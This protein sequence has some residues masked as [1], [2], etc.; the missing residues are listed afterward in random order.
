M[1]FLESQMKPNR[2]SSRRGKVFGEN[3]GF[4]TEEIAI[5]GFVRE[6]KSEL[7]KGQHFSLKETEY[8]KVADAFERLWSEK[9]VDECAFMS[10]SLFSKLC[11]GKQYPS[12][13]W[14]KNI[15]TLFPGLSEKWFD[16]YVFKNRMQ[17]HLAS[18]DLFHIAS[19]CR[20]FF[21]MRREEVVD[22][23]TICQE[24]LIEA[25]KEAESI[26]KL[27]HED[28]EPRNTG[29]GNNY[30]VRISGPHERSGLN[31]VDNLT[32][33]KYP[34]FIDKS[35]FIDY[36]LSL[37]EASFIGLSL[38]GEIVNTYQ[39][40]NPF[41]VVLFLFLLVGLDQNTKSEYR[42][43][44]ILDFMTSLNC[45]GLILK[46]RYEGLATAQNDMAVK[47]ILSLLQNVSEYFHDKPFDISEQLEACEQSLKHAQKTRDATSLYFYPTPETQFSGYP[48][49]ILTEIFLETL[50]FHAD[51]QN[52]ENL[53]EKLQKFSH[54][55]TYKEAKSDDY[56]RSPFAGIFKSFEAS[57]ERYLEQ[58]SI[59]GYSRD[60]LIA[61]LNEIITN[62]IVI[63]WGAAE[64]TPQ[65]PSPYLRRK[66]PTKLC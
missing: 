35:E 2:Y 61:E 28:W 7:L 16:R 20:C 25:V 19:D 43:D 34:D 52:I 57:R 33:Y 41:S 31:V 4:R 3:R 13:A 9:Q 62:P 30:D 60:E 40:E 64:Q 39:I 65:K 44:L 11:N 54:S 37:G 12:D 36:D 55:N 56:L 58:F 59:T 18:I 1:R 63:K 17:L 49:Y 53:L 50:T 23:E 22:S 24:C 27:I 48:G 46:V 47:T 26:L 45:A 51:G 10:D 5:R 38:P 42:N 32:H 21:R 66:K 15:N 6:F 29:N 8:K 14:R